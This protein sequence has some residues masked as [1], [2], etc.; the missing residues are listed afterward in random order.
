MRV[1]SLTLT[2]SAAGVSATGAPLRCASTFTAS[3]W[4]RVA[5]RDTVAT[6]R[7][8]A[9][10]DIGIAVLAA[11]GSGAEAIADWTGTA[12]LRRS[13][14]ALFEVRFLVGAAIEPAGELVFVG[15][16][17]TARREGRGRFTCTVRQL[18]GA[19]GESAASA[20]LLDGSFV[21]RF[22]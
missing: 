7:G 9:G 19:S 10:G 16:M 20:L 15:T 22:D 5:T 17:D 21:A 6:Y 4:E 12:V 1:S 8:E 13:R 11:D 2:A 3:R 14:G 18:G